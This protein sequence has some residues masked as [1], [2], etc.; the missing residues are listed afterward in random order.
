MRILFIALLVPFVLSSCRYFGGEWVSG[1]GKIVSQQKD[2]GAFNSVEVHGSVDVRIRQDAGNSVKVQTDENLFEFIDIY[3]EGNTL[4]IRPRQGYRLDPSKGLVAYI[5]APSFRKVDLSGDCNIT[6][7]GTISGTEELAIEVS[8]SGD[9][10]MDVS[11]T[12]IRT[13]ISGSGSVVLRGK[14]SEFEARVS[15][16]GDVKCF[17][18]Q[19]ERTAL[20]ISGSAGAEIS[21][22]QDLDVHI[23]GSGTVRYKGPATLHQHVSGSGDIEKVG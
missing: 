23:S 20:D 19:T 5:S 9:I 22:S 10:K 11:L 17:E 15:G 12:K 6:S 2:V 7:E 1:N 3:T 13:Q 14:A 16:S 4:V 18:L 21:A 8:G